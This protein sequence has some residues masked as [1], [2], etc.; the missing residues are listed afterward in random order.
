MRRE[1]TTMTRVHGLRSLA[2]AGVLAMA[3]IGCK[4]PPPSPTPDPG[5]PAATQAPV[6]TRFAKVVSKKV[7][8][9]LETSG[10]LDPDERSEVAAQTGGVVQKVLVDAGTRVKK[11]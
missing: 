8:R 1:S 11:G 6:T 9:A 4:K 3:V 10:T 2:A 7:A 5:K